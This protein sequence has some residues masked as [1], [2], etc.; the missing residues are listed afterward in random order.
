VLFRASVLPE[1]R[2]LSGDQGA[3]SIIDADPARVAL[4]DLDRPMPADV[5][6]AEDLAAL[7]TRGAAPEV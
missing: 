3:R 5:D 7:R 1:V 4:V 2:A 6:T